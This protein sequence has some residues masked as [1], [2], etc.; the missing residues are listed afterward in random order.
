MEQPALKRFSTVVIDGVE[1]RIQRVPP[2]GKA[3]FTKRPVD[4]T[5]SPF[6]SFRSSGGSKHTAF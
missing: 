4:N 2:R 5:Q 6:D 3:K 1:H